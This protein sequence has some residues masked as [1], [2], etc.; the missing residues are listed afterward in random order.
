VLDIDTCKG[1]AMKFKVHGYT[2]EKDTVATYLTVDE[3]V[4]AG[5]DP[6]RVDL[7]DPNPIVKEIKGQ[8]L[9]FTRL[10]NVSFAYKKRLDSPIVVGFHD[11]AFG[12]C[13]V[14]QRRIDH[15]EPPELRLEAIRTSD[16]SFDHHLREYL[17]MARHDDRSDNG[18]WNTASFRFAAR[19]ASAVHFEGDVL[20]FD[21]AEERLVKADSYPFTGEMFQ[22][23][24]FL[25]IAMPAEIS[26]V[27]EGFPDVRLA[28]VGDAPRK[29]LTGD[30]I[31]QVDFVVM[32]DPHSWENLELRIAD[33][34]QKPVPEKNNMYRS[35]DKEFHVGGCRYH[36]RWNP[37]PTETDVSVVAR[38]WQ[39]TFDFNLSI[40]GLF[41]V[42]QGEVA[43]G[44]RI[45]IYDV[46]SRQVRAVSEWGF[47]QLR[48]NNK[49]ARR[50]KRLLK[51][52]RF[53]IKRIPII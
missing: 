47:R 20:H 22:E 15:R 44:T 18:P 2:D 40:G 28:V 9:F 6:W 52:A 26:L 53:T 38:K 12:A 7:F 21:R 1:S 34:T 3:I 11:G 51:E 48:G 10:V 39:Q 41:C 43:G 8:Q 23:M 35:A 46:A 50:R 27:F 16:R 42:K 24:P 32:L 14:G 33:L 19:P 37:Y 4:E 25:N 49:E 29:M 13:F 36:V 17:N 30:P 45:S 5:I 31:T